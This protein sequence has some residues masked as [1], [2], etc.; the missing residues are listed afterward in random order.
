MKDKKSYAVFG[1]GRYGMAVAEGLVR[2]GADVLAVDREEATVN[3][4]AQTLPVCKCADA[5]DREVM[6]QLGVKDVDV[7]IV[8]MAGELEGSILV[9]MLC[10]DAGIPLVIAKCA[11]DLH[12]EILA[13]VGADK[14]V[15]PER[16]SGVRLAK[17]LLSAGFVDMIELSDKAAVVEIAPPAD[18]V[19]KTLKELELRRY[20]G[21]NVVAVR[22][23]K[24]V[25]VR[26]DPDEPLR[27][28]ERLVVIASP[29]ALKKL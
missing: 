28:T 20:H 7:A 1:L 24:S 14:V 25:D 29:E 27:D 9:T 22:R 3:A 12:G 19:G 21:I 18:W 4:A 23:E 13:R 10:K 8:A 17:N 16:D 15:Y 5:T 2:A 11:N 26:V 6:Q